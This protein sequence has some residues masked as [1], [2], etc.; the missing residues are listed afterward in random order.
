MGYNI[1][2]FLLKQ[3]WGE[4]IIILSS[5]EALSLKT[6]ELIS[7]DLKEFIL[8]FCKE[9]WEKAVHVTVFCIDHG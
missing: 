8:L 2:L 6:D 3:G 1:L 7:L 4:V 5:L 9:I